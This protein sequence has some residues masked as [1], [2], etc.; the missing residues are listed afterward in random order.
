MA[1]RAQIEEQLS[2]KTEPKV[3][4]E[5]KKG[6][7]P[8]LKWS[9]SAASWAN[10]LPKTITLPSKWSN[11][12]L[13][14]GYP[15]YVALPGRDLCE[16]M[17]LVS[18]APFVRKDAQRN[19]AYSGVRK[20]I[21]VWLEMPQDDGQGGEGP[22]MVEGAQGS[23]AELL[24]LLATYGGEAQATTAYA[25]KL[26]IA[27]KAGRF[28]QPGCLLKVVAEATNRIA[29]LRPSIETSLGA[30][31]EAIT[32]YSDWAAISGQQ[33]VFGVGEDGEPSSPEWLTAIPLQITH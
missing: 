23:L 10:N 5:T 33:R 18:Y 13:A 22:A 4:A 24:E 7:F 28:C 3:T 11:I 26:Y 1:M 15:A 27:D 12:I 8:A 19:R 14:D 16:T 9:E 21:R 2:S 6:R 17:E 31:P 32:L 30:I 20:L 29:V 25:Q